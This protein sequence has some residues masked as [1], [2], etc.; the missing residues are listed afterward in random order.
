LRHVKK[1]ADGD[2]SF[3]TEK[4]DRLNRKHAV[5]RRYHAEKGRKKI[6]SQ[7]LQGD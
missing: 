1:P 6:L 2:L 4:K 5:R 3:P 7:T